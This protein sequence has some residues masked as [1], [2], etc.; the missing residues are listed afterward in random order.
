[1][2]FCKQYNAA[3]ESQRGT[4]VPAEITVFEDR[5]FTFVT[6][7][8][9]HAGAAAGRRRPRQGLRRPRA[10]RRRARSPTPSSPRS[11]STK[12]PDLNANDLEA[13]KRQV[14]GTARSMGITVKWLTDDP[15][16]EEL[17]EVRRR[18]PPVR[19][20]TASTARARPS[21]WSRAWPSAKFDETVEL[22]VR[23][24]VDPRKADQIVRGTVGLPAGTGK[25]GPG[26]RLR[27]RP[28][29][30]P[31]PGRPAPTWSAPT[32]WW[33]GSRAASSTSTWPSPP[34]TSWARS[35]SWAGSS[36]P[37]ASCPTPRP[38]PSPPT[39]AGPSREFKGGRVEYRTDR[40]GNI[41]VPIG[42]V[43]FDRRALLQN[44]RAVIEELQ[45]GQ[46]G[47]GQGPVHAGHHRVVHHGPRRQGRPQPAP[48]PRRRAGGSL[49]RLGGAVVPSR[50]TT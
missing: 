26:G 28:T 9:A 2:E 7:D 23:L 12:M 34:P 17:Q 49:L 46:A 27:R 5:S 10:G 50:S 38:A 33:P 21:T 35:A 20:Q 18:R 37:G 43:S 45:P 36:V 48:C 6:Q 24:G 11:P 32:T 40:Y 44:L 13:A 25:D 41:H 3:S 14:A 47:L 15:H 30:P 29:P 16:Q 4:V 19:P 1:M 31:R 39:W 8:A 22:A 42:K